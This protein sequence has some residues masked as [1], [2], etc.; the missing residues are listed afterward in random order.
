MKLQDEQLRLQ[1][2]E[3]RVLK[4]EQAMMA[5]ELKKS[6]E[7]EKLLVK[8]MDLLNEQNGKLQAN[9]KNLVKELEIANNALLDSAKAKEELQ[10]TKV[11]EAGNS[12][13][14]QHQINEL[15]TRDCTRS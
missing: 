9:F 8:E 12:T 14:L 5:R 15:K 7:S 4:E 3:I 1:I 2:E 6:K 10:A 11:S 13:R